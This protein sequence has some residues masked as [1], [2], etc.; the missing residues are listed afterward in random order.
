MKSRKDEAK[1]E[2]LG[3]DF[4]SATPEKYAIRVEDNTDCAHMTVVILRGGHPH[5]IL[6]CHKDREYP[7]FTMN[8]HNQIMWHGKEA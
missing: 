4:H 5:R 3:F 7:L 6:S 1:T 2:V 8:A